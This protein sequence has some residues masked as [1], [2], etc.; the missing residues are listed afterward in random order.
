MS[1]SLTF[2]FCDADRKMANARAWVQRSRAIMMPGACAVGAY[3][4]MAPMGRRL[5]C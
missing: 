3:K 1:R 4:L 5:T 2:L